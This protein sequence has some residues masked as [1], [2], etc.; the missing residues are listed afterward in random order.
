M[1][2]ENPNGKS[3]SVRDALQETS[4]PGLRVLTSGPMVSTPAQLIESDLFPQVLKQ[5]KEECDYVVF[6]TP[7]IDRVSDG[8]TIASMVDGCIFVVGSGQ[9]EQRD[10]TWAKHL[11]TN[12]QANLLG[13]F[14]NRYSYG[15]TREYEYYA[16]M[17][18]KV[19]S[20]V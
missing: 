9:C 3:V 5:L 18:K 19:T 15:K 10:I 12:V 4:V 17:E 7:P 1:G 13:V 2:S 11:L 20:T 6:D 16:R 8:L 14:L